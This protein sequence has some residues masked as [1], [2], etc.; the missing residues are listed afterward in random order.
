MRRLWSSA[1]AI[2]IVGAIVVGYLL[3]VQK[4]EDNVEPPTC[5]TEDEVLVPVEGGWSTVDDADDLKCV[6][7]D[8]LVEVSRVQ[9]IANEQAGDDKPDIKGDF[10]EFRLRTPSRPNG[11]PCVAWTD[12]KSS[13]DAAYSYSGLTCDWNRS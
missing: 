7:I 4:G 1:E 3:G 13:G 8:T 11:M 2:I 10:H 5:K 9:R 12:K 6:H